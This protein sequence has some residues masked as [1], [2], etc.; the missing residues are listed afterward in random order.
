MIRQTEK[1]KRAERNM[2]EN[3]LGPAHTGFISKEDSNTFGISLSKREKR[4]LSK[5]RAMIEGIRKEAG[6]SKKTTR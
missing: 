6:K 5:K 2:L 4:L 1:Q 3:S